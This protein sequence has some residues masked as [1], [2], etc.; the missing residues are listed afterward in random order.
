MQWLGPSTF[1]VVAHVQFLI[2][3]LSFRKP[4]SVAKKKIATFSEI[5]ELSCPQLLPA[6]ISMAQQTTLLWIYRFSQS[7]SSVA[8]SCPT[9]CDTM[10]CRTPGLPVHQQL[11][12]FTQTHVHRVR[13]PSSHLISVIPF[14]SC[15][16]PSQH[17]GLFQWVNS[18]HKVAE[19][20]EFQLQHQ[21]FQWTP[22]TD[23]L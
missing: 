5:L 8:Q 11:P 4:Q 14:S 21:S 19:V 18:S 3:K 16:Q 15:P 10:N 20:L 2:W 12:E 17:Q 22:R 1:T 23:L 7:V 13:T 6:T 9:L